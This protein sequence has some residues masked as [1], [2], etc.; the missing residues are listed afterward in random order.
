M[1]VQYLK[2]KQNREIGSRQIIILMVYFPT[3]TNL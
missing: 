1:W 2:I 3:A